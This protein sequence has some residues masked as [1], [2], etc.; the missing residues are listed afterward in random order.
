MSLTKKVQF[1][2]AERKLRTSLF[3]NNTPINILGR[4][5]LCVLKAN[6]TCTQRGLQVDFPDN[7]ECTIMSATAVVNTEMTVP[8][9]VYRL[10][11]PQKSELEQL[12]YE[13]EKLD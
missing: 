4:D 8:P 10:R 5:V 9:V 12:L 3:S 7:E 13:M 2:V 6:I 1:T 11:W